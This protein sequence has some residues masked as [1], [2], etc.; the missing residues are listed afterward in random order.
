MP[1]R[2]L[3]GW[4][5][6]R[7]SPRA[8]RRTSAPPARTRPR[9]DLSRIAASLNLRRGGVGSAFVVNPADLQVV[10]LLAALEGKLDIGVLGNAAAPVGDECRL[11]V[12]LKGQ[13][14]D[15]MRRND[16]AFGVLDE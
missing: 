8:L 2:R 7:R 13:L 9:Q 6:R 14:L 5:C 16:L 3:P 11:A 10:T 1:W 15:K 4:A 12:I